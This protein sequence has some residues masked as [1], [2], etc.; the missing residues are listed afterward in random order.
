MSKHWS[1]DPEIRERTIQKLRD[2]KSTSTHKNRMF[3]VDNP[4]K[5]EEVRKKIADTVRRRWEEGRYSTRVNGMTDKMKWEHPNFSMKNSFKEYAYSWHNKD[6]CVECGSIDR[7]LNVHHIDE[8]WDNW[9]LTNLE[10]LCVTCHQKYHFT[11]DGNDNTLLIKQPYVLSVKMFKFESAHK[12]IGSYSG[13][14]DSIHGHSYRFEIGVRKRLRNDGI[15]IDFSELS[16]IVKKYVVDIL[17]HS[18]LNDVLDNPTAENLSLWIWDVL[19]KDALL[20]GMNRVRLWET[21]SSY[22][23]ITSKD[24][25]SVIEGNKLDFDSRVTD[26]LKNIKTEVTI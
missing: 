21:D 4:T 2:T 26:I 14:C 23:E 20:K 12:L 10:P 13:L 17:D 25:M 11:H 3:G 16:E 7:K 22:V 9:T 6:E 15:T 24:V 18:Y 8:D 5:R 1:K 19:E